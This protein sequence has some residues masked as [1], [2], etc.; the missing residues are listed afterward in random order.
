MLWLTIPTALA[1]SWAL[2]DAGAQKPGVR[3]V[4]VCTPGVPGTAYLPWAHA[5]EK[6]G[7]DAWMVELVTPDQSVDQAVDGLQAA[8][9]QVPDGWVLAAHGYGGVLA[10]LAE[11]RASRMALVGTPLSAHVVPPMLRDPGAIVSEGM[12]FDPAWIGD[13]PS[14]PYSGQL[15]TAYAA[16]ATDFPDYRAPAHPTLVVASNIDPVAPP[17]ITRL[18]SQDWPARSW[19]RAGMLAVAEQDLT[20]AQL[21]TDA[22]TARMVARF[23]A[24]R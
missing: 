8:L 13:L 24:D 22:R 16:W 5:L 12:P 23:L 1:S 7:L 14:T 19:H 21:L 20:H 3:A 18:P 4:I 17:E 11:P 2:T 6:A 15:G 10:L 9:G